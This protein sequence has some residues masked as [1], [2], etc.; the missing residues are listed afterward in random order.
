MNA[1]KRTGSPMQR[2]SPANGPKSGDVASSTM[3]F[4]SISTRN[5]KLLGTSA[6]LLVTSALL[7]VTRSYLVTSYISMSS[8][9]V[10]PSLEI[11]IIVGSCLFLLDFLNS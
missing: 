8:G 5:K 3:E 10:H 1:A 11:E 7:V 6:S 4:I 2:L 9:G